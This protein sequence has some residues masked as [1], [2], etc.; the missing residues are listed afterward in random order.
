MQARLKPRNQEEVDR[1]LAM[2][3]QDIHAKLNLS[4]LASGDVMFAATGVTGGDFLKGVRFR[5]QGALTQSVVMR[6]Q[7][8][9]LRYIDAE[10]NFR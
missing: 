7:T 9:T 8:G 2:G 5:S 4:D 6:S 10:H 1:A 3:V